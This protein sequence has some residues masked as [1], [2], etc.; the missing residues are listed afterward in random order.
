M[1]DKVS[2]VMKVCVI[3]GVEF[4]PKRAFK[5]CSEVCSGALTRKHHRE[6]STRFLEKNNTPEYKAKQKAYH[7]AYRAKKKAALDKK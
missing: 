4:K 7:Q 2:T 1:V 5:T 3:C 6:A